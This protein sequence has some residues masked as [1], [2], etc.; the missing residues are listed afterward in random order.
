MDA[1]Q[2]KQET[3]K[4]CHLLHAGSLLGL[5]L[6]PADRSNMFLQTWL[7]PEWAIRWHILARLV[8]DQACLETTTG[9]QKDT[10]PSSV[11][12]FAAEKRLTW[13]LSTSCRSSA[14]PTGCAGCLP[15][16]LTVSLLEFQLCF[17]GNVLN[18]LWFFQTQRPVRL[19]HMSTTEMCE[20]QIND[21][22]LPH[23]FLNSHIFIKRKIVFKLAIWEG[24]VFWN[25]VPD[26]FESCY[27]KNKH[28]RNLLLILS[29]I[30]HSFK[31]LTF[32][33]ITTVRDESDATR[34]QIYRNRFGDEQGGVSI[35]ERQEA[36]NVTCKLFIDCHLLRSNSAHFQSNLFWHALGL[37][38]KH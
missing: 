36:R 1:Q 12:P 22:K 37:I 6:S 13:R 33:F 35:C 32:H 7:H 26:A 21:D 16:S 23:E 15:G 9:I 3:S 11:V 5:S 25:G 34:S 10:E 24:P 31:Q 19:F 17:G 14:P 20:N 18:H 29:A 8:E 38:R 2:P 4:V 30:K 28:N 27:K